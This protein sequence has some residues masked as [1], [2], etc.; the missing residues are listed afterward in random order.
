MTPP[1]RRQAGRP[2]K[3]T[4][5]KRPE[6]RTIMVFCE[7]VK[8]EPDYVKALKRLPHI[9]KNTALELRIYHEPGVPLTLVENALV[10]KRDPEIDECWCLF[11]VE[12]PK[13]HPR[14]QE[15]I[16]LARANDINLAISNPC[17]ELWLV[18]HFREHRAFVNTTPVE[19]LSRTLDNRDGKSIDADSYMALRKTAADRAVRLDRRHEQDGTQFPHNNPSSG[20]HKFLKALEGD[21]H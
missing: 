2:L 20:M 18:L 21:Q 9:A 16:S 14:L 19:R 4:T 7:G 17:F 8:S 6:L 13:H 12:W 10:F 5:E 11:D 1:K 3:R 15:A